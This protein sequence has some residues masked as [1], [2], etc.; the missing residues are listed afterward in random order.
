[1]NNLRCRKIAYAKGIPLGKSAYSTGPL[2]NSS[3][4]PVKRFYPAKWI[5]Q[6]R[7]IQTN[8]LTTLH[9]LI[10]VR[11]FSKAGGRGDCLLFQSNIY[12]LCFGV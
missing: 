5:L 11:H 8:K 2:V 10:F 7:R 3:D 1:M 12:S 6:A 9:K 4:S